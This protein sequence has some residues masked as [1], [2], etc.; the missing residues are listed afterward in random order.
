[1][2]QMKVQ[3]GFKRLQTSFFPSKQGQ[4]CPSSLAPL[5]QK[6]VEF[7]QSPFHYPNVFRVNGPKSHD[8]SIQSKSPGSKYFEEQEFQ[9]RRNSAFKSNYILTSFS[10]EGPVAQRRH[11][12]V[13]E[14]GKS[15]ILDLTFINEEIMDDYDFQIQR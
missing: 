3:P 15:I 2:H 5:D 7:C 10:K 4:P 11:T 13:F 12:K 1:M 9:A 6:A 8:N 14:K